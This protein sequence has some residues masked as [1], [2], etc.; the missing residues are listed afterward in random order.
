MQI[1]GNVALVTGAASGLGAASAARL[2]AG[3][4]RIVLADISD[5]DAPQGDR[6]VRCNVTSEEDVQAAGDKLGKLL[7]EVHV[8]LTVA[9]PLGGEERAKRKLREMAGAFGQ[10]SSPRLASFSATRVHRRRGPPRAGGRGSLLSTEELA[11]LFT[12]FRQNFHISG[13]I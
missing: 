8:R 11:T 1:A 7:F 3:G 4:A 13:T 9:G 6:F 5:V 2:R 12:A 10:F